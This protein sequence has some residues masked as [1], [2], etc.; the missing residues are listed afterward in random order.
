LRNLKLH[1]EAELLGLVRGITVMASASIA[2]FELRAALAAAHRDH[3]LP[4]PRLIEA[5]GALERVWQ[6][7]SP[8]DVDGDLVQDAGDLAEQ[9]KLRGYDAVLL[10]ALRRLGTAVEVDLVACWDDAVRIAA[11]Q[12]GYHLFPA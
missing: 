2:Y 10:A 3:R 5:R 8:L 4:R 7:T 9:M 6:A 11:A 12:L 1:R